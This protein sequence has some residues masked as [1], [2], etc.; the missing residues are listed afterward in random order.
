M[1]DLRQTCNGKI[2]QVAFLNEVLRL[3]MSFSSACRSGRV[4]AFANPSASTDSQDAQC[5]HFHS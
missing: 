3:T 1:H 5:S 4:M 2:H